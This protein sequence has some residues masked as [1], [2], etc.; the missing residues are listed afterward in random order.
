MHGC[1]SRIESAKQLELW[2][3]LAI[4]VMTQSKRL[5]ICAL[6]LVIKSVHTQRGNPN[7]SKTL[8]MAT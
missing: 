5:H 1:A 4:L 2:L 3:Q 7:C 8:H 6:F